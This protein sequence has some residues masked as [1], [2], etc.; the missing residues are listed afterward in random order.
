MTRDIRKR[1]VRVG[2]LA[3]ALAVVVA[4]MPLATTDAA[5]APAADL[6]VSDPLPD[7]APNETGKL[8]GAIDVG[9]LM[10]V[11]G[12]DPSE[13]PEETRGFTGQARTWGNDAGAVAVAFVIDCGDESSAREFLRGAL[14][15]A[16]R[17][18]DSTFD[19]GMFGT[20]GF[21]AA[22]A[23]SAVHTVEWRQSQY[24]V[25]VFIV[26]VSGDASETDIRAL[27]SSQAAFL[28]S[29]GHGDPSITVSEAKADTGALY[30]VGYVV[31][32]LMIPAAIG[33]WLLVR[34]RRRDEERQHAARFAVPPAPFTSAPSSTSAPL[35]PPSPPPPLP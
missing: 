25:E 4:S 30:Q 21:A 27:A 22:T 33:I 17:T 24:F 20:A 1:T 6:I 23:S 15:G 10:E 35:P 26:G 8:N 5:T 14:D 9:T 13:I 34:K 32:L 7:Y 31:G 29:N 28:R 11:S 2:A 16:R 3:L 19:S 18:S 12:S